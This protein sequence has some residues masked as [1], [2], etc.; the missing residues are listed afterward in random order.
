VSSQVR[1]ERE[2][3]GVEF[4]RV[5]FFADAV[6]AIAI[7]LL[8][9]EVG[10]PEIA[11]GED[12]DGAGNLLEAVWDKVPV[13]AAFFVGCFAIGGYWLAAHRF[14]SRL[15]AVDRRH[16]VLTVVYLAF[17]AFLPFAVGTLGEYA[18]NPMSVAIFAVNMGIVSG[19]E[20]VL[21][22]HAAAAHLFR[23]DLPAPVLRW[24]TL[25]SGL[26]V[27][28]FALSVPI[29]FLHPWLGVLVWVG[30]VPMQAVFARWRPADAGAYVG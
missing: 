28:L 1:Y 26:P 5:V 11:A 8:I 17:V 25:A 10:L 6:F 16:L 20:V 24:V 18:T 23:E 13:I 27:A 15:S 2:S 9:V 4:D 22:R 12:R 3:D 19:L 30:A 14:M 21:I 29:A 7:T